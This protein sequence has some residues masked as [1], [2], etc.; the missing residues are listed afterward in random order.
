MR[1]RCVMRQMKP[2]QAAKHAHRPGSARSTSTHSRSWRWTIGFLLDLPLDDAYELAAAAIRLAEAAMQSSD[3]TEM[4]R[5]P[6]GSWFAP[7]IVGLHARAC[8]R[9]EGAD[10]LQ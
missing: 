6:R 9:R 7:N 1:A 3:L 10:E 2:A 8:L 4:P 5:L